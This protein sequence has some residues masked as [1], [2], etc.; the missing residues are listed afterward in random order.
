MK[1]ILDNF[2]IDEQFTRNVYHRPKKF[3]HVKDNVPHHQYYNYGSD[4]LFMP[5]DKQGNKYCLVVVDLATDQF[6]IEPIKNKEAETVLT[7]FKKMFKR[8]FIHKPYVSVRTDAG[9]EFQ[10]AFHKYLW[11]ENVLHSVAL[12]NRHSQ[13]ANAENLNKQLGRVFAGY[14]NMKELE[15]KKVYREWTDI[16][17]DVRTV[18]NEYRKKQ[19]KGW[20]TREYASPSIRPAK[21]DVG[22]MVH[23]RLDA[24]Q[25]ALGHPQP[26]KQFREGDF[27][28]SPIAEKVTQVLAYPMGS[29]YILNDRRNVSYTENQLL[30][31]DQLEQ[32]WI[33]KNIIGKKK[34]KGELFYLVHWKN[35]AAKDATWEPKT[36]LIEDNVGPLIDVYEQQLKDEKKSKK[37]IG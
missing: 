8:P 7:A 14:L 20:E 16:L 35:Y 13:N 11:N 27:R 17:S 5:E 31:S 4:L 19:N 33:V 23:Y 2:G 1:A 22:N 21:F 25:N 34:M 10:G 9:S 36:H 30:K 37:N 15:T 6:D 29:R 3:D 24:P 32:K 28:Y 18:L 26:T 12:P